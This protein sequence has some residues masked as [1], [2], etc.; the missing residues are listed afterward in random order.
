MSRAACLTLLLLVSPLALAH[1][2]PTPIPTCQGGVGAL[3]EYLPSPPSFYSWSDGNLADCD[4]D[5]VP[6]DYDREPDFGA[7][8]ARLFVGANVE[9]CFGPGHVAHHGTTIRALDAAGFG[10][11]LL[12]HADN[13]RAIP[14]EP[15]DCGDGVLD[16]CPDTREPSQAPPP[17]NGV[18]DTAY[19][20]YDSLWVSAPCNPNDCVVR[21]PSVAVGPTVVAMP[22]G[23][24]A[25]GS[26][27][28]HVEYDLFNARVP[29]GGHIWT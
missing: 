18:I 20:A 19:A 21:A 13:S 17:L 12:I 16:P 29:T 24:G 1:D 11:A 25:D 4:A 10:P 28:V 15:I 22:C 14:V 5:G 26:Y 6:V 8:Y 7:N 23:P 9:T 2:P 27:E 3:H